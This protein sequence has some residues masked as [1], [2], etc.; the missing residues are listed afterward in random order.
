MSNE[1]I[2]MDKPRSEILA[3]PAG[4]LQIAVQRGANIEE[5][6]SLMDLQDR[7]EANQAR[8]AYVQAMAEFK[9]NPPVIFKAK[10]VGYKTKEGD[11]VGYKHATLGDVTSITIEALAKHQFSHRWDVEQPGDGRVIVRCILTHALGHSEKNTMEAPIDTSGKKNVIQQIASTITYLQRYT[12]LATCGLAAQDEV[13]PDDDGKGAGK[14]KEAARPT[15]TDI[16]FKKALTAIK[17]KTYT[18]AR[19]L[20]EYTLTVDQETAFSDA[21]KEAK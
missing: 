17:A 19:A 10:E 18:L 8:K 9:L 20:E 5:L 14:Q 4:L 13:M 11:F 2:E 6:R 15:L 16:G 1:I 21:E 12:L 7:Y 3:T